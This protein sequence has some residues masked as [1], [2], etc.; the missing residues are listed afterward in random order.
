MSSTTTRT[1]GD[2]L[3]DLRPDDL[4][5][6]PALAHP[7]SD[8]KVLLAGTPSNQAI[9]DASKKFYS[10][11]QRVVDTSAINTRDVAQNQK[12]YVSTMNGYDWK[13]QQLTASQR[14]TTGTALFGGGAAGAVAAAGGGI[15]D[16]ALDEVKADQLFST[17]GLGVTLDLQVFV[18]GAG[19]LGC[20]W[21]IAKREDP[22][23][24]G[25]A[26]GELGLRV[27]AELNVQCLITNQLPSATSF[28]IFGLKVSVSYGLSLS[29]Q[30]FW[31]GSELTLLGYGIGAGVGLGGGATV[32]GGHIWNFG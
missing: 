15:F 24:Y 21:D 14:A 30:V 27:T 9:L 1:L 23:G 4:V 20:M 29:F 2:V 8:G 25:F 6:S 26:T 31:M 32:F 3:E 19:G 5:L 11:H 13:S 22:R 10:A 12:Q 7:G 16:P 28:D 17:I 18:G